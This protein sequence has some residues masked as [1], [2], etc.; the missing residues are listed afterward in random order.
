MV[1]TKLQAIMR[2]GSL[3]SRLHALLKDK[4]GAQFVEILI[5]ILIAIVVGGIALKLTETSLLEI[6]PM[7]VSKI[8]SIFSL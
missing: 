5:G 4:K 7:I 6:G 1:I 3:K 8:K 2:A